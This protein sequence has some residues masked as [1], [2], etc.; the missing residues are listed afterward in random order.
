MI[1]PKRTVY[2]LNMIEP[3]VPNGTHGNGYLK[4]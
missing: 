3:C 4:Y 1:Y 2:A